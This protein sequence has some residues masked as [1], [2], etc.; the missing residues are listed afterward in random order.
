MITIYTLTYNEELLIQFRIDHYRERFP[1]CRMVFYD[2]LSTDNTVKIAKENGCEVITYD[3]G[4]Q[5]SD[6]VHMDIKNNCWKDAQTDWVLQSDLDELLDINEAE[7]KEEERL[8]TSMIRCQFW[9]MVNMEDN[10]DFKAM[11]YGVRSPMLP[12]KFLLFNKK[13]ISEIN[14]SPGAHAC[15]PI[16]TITY[17]SKEYRVYHYVSINADVTIKKFKIRRETLSPENIKMGWGTQVFMT[18]DEIYT[19]YADE[20]KKAV[21]VR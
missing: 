3:T 20:R 13:F 6:R 21:K 10:L 11:K 9:D 7:L 19:E 16:G 14:Y 2:N 12:G 4:G 1:N 17:S 5:F 18:P 8:G 15:N